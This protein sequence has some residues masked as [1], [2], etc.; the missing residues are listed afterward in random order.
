M[1][2]LAWDAHAY[3]GAAAGALLGA[4]TYAW[5][6][7]AY[8]FD[9]PWLVGIFVGLA[10]AI[11]AR[12]RSALRGIV[13]ATLA[14]WVGATA[15]CACRPADAGSGILAEFTHY[16]QRVDA[17]LLVQQ[18]LSGSAAGVL[19]CRALRHDATVRIAGAPGRDV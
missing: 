16:H 1:N 6:L 9:W 3:A 2:W 12:E 4:L 19:G 11:S 15:Q 8:G 14:I 7:S 5:L 10:C 17:W 18:V 13:V